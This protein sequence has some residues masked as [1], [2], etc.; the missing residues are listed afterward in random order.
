MAL[1]HELSRFD[2]E[3]P[4]LLRT[5]RGQFVLIHK[6]DEIAGAYRT[7]DEAYEAGCA[8]H[9]IEPFLVMLVEDHEKPIPLLQDIKPY[10]DPQLFP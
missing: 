10:A 8:K 1:E 3:L 9:G 6:D 4:R 7:E 2:Q 5:M